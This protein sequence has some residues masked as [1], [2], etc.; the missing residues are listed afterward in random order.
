MKHI[1]NYL[2]LMLASFFFAVSM[3]A[4]QMIVKEV[5][6]AI[7]TFYQFFIAAIVMFIYNICRHV[8]LKLEKKDILYLIML[9]FFGYTLSNTLFN[10]GL[11]ISSAINASIIA[12]TVP[13]FTMIISVIFLKT[14]VAILN[15]T[16]ICISIFGVLSMILDWNFA[17]LASIDNKGDLL[18]ILGVITFCVYLIKIE[19]I[20]KKYDTLIIVMYMF[21]FS[22]LTTIP[23]MIPELG[24]YDIMNTSTKTWV[25]VFI[26][27]VF[28]GGVAYSLQQFCIKK[29]G[30]II[31]SLI[32]NLI[33]IFVALLSY[34]LFGT[35]ISTKILLSM[36]II[37]FGVVSS[38]L[39]HAYY[40]KN[41][42]IV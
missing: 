31:T 25:A 38:T 36:F 17:K 22:L 1:L 33:P 8:S 16:A 2:S 19:S 18:F 12:S 14:K 37:I 23:F 32:T 42:T 40:I 26:T 4:N 9:S 21:I 5:N 24:S 30:P 13:I 15:I 7:A 34:V 27:G 35:L 10:E 29:L 39:I 3:I 28:G 11:K 6:P 20:L 41:N